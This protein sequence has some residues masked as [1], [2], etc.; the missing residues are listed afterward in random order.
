MIHR[1]LDLRKTYRHLLSPPT[2]EVQVVDVPR[3]RF[4]MVDGAGDPN[5]GT[6]QDA[7]QTLYG[8]SYTTKFALKK[9][10]IEYP[11]MALEGLWWT[12]KSSGKFDAKARDKWKWTAMIMQ[13]EVATAAK[14]RAAAAELTRKGKHLSKYRVEDFQEG[15]SAQVMHV[16]PYSAEAPTIEKMR[17]FIE[18]NGFSYNGR[19]HEIYLGDPRRA[20]PS[21]L[22]TI[23]RQ[24][25]RRAPQ[26]R[27]S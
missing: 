1:K 11:V 18:K 16:G 24:P 17:E 3:L 5:S 23:L 9:E 27:Q 6:F 20:A 4:I 19:H 14:I 13:P 8:L 25:I 22:R 26:I 21:K 15:L 7:I 12:G 2:D 10:G